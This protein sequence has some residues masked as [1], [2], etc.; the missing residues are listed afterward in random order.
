MGTARREFDITV[1]G[2][3]GFTGGLIAAYLAEHARITTE[4]DSLTA[5]P[6]A[7]P[8]DDADEVVARLRKLRETWT[9]GTDDARLALVGRIYRRITVASA[10]PPNIS[11][12]DCVL[13]AGR[14]GWPSAT[15]AS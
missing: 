6:A 13:R 14:S 1:L 8:I 3:T 12:H 7:T 5:V 4:I 15:V 9:K 10:S 11:N 2:A